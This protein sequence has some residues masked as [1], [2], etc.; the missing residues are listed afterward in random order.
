MQRHE[1]FLAPTSLKVL[2]VVREY[3]LYLVDVGA[4]SSG[5]SINLPAI[6]AV[7]DKKCG[8]SVTLGLASPRPA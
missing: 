8:R 7:F 4:S 5:V 6:R 2:C 3:L 1:T